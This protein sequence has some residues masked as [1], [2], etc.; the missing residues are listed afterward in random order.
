MHTVP[1]STRVHILASSSPPGPSRAPCPLARRSFAFLLVLSTLPLADGI[2]WLQL[3]VPALLPA[4]MV[5]LGR[6]P[7]DGGCSAPSW[8]PR[9]A[10]LTS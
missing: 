6:M 4:G 7:A 3:C 5:T 8:A 10:C 9:S 1:P 2:M